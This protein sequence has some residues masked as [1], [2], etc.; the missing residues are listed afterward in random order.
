MERR[1]V[2]Q[3]HPGIRIDKIPASGIGGLLF[4]IATVVMFLGIPEVREFMLVGVAGGIPM[5]ALLYYWHNQT[6]W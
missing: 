4:T 3:N 1:S 2:M 5:A 6:R